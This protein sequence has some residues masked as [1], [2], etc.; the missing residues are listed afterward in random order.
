MD[1]S[2]RQ[3]ITLAVAAVLVGGAWM[4][5][6]LTRDDG[7]AAGTPTGHSTARAQPE[8]SEAGTG[9]GTKSGGFGGS[10]A[11]GDEGDEGNA[12]ARGARAAETM[13]IETDRFVATVTSRNTGLTSFRVKKQRYR[14]DK[15]QP[16][17]LVTTTEPRFFP[18]HVELE[19]VDIPD[20]A[21]WEME[22][23]SGQGIRFHWSGDGVAI[24]RKLQVGKGPYQLW[25]TVRIRNTGTESRRLTLTESTFHYIRREDE[26][27]GFLARPSPN[28]SLGVCMNRQEDAWELVRKDREELLEPHGYGPPVRY[29]G[30]QDV[31]FANVIVAAEQD[32]HRCKMVSSNRGGVPGDPEGSLFESRL[33]YDDVELGGGKST[34]FRTF[35]YFGPKRQATLQAAGRQLPRL[36]DLGWF[37]F[38]GELLSDLLSTIHEFVGNWGLAIILLTL[39]VKLVLYPLTEK[40]FRSMARMRQLKP[41]MDRINELYADDKEKK[42][43]AIMEL[44]RKHKINP[45][46]GCL[47]TL[48]Q[49]P[50]WL[51]LYQSLS[52]NVEL[53]NADFVLW[54]TD[55]SSPDPYFVL[56][57]MVGGLMFLQQRLTPTAMD[58]MQAK[59]M[60]YMMPVMI[61]GFMLFLPAGLCLYIVT[62]SAL[63]IGQQQLIQRRLDRQTPEGETEGGTEQ[64]TGG[65]GSP[66]SG[67]GEPAPAPPP[68][69]QP[70]EAVPALQSSGGGSSAAAAPKP[71][72]KSKKPTSKPSSRRRGGKRRQHRGR[73]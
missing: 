61:T 48:L 22:R 17:Q 31:Y 68:R 51:A 26:G 64:S 42:G 21:V 5:T 72:T 12:P 55:L 13:T 52:T 4:A 57:L 29:T 43:A 24:V 27:G 1:D 63:S 45:L 39:V 44:Y 8:T 49:L 11:A 14:N 71:R 62:N 40:S 3:M 65:N 66:P 30:I 46:G 15:G 36:V 28:R 10:A 7:G 32:A 6:D 33:V 35:A 34:T 37:A 50:I 53:Y 18:L 58:P 41:E 19:G 38:I 16:Q 2:R 60:M 56:P 67:G 25:S 73:A 59:I 20:D 54:W 69:N 23:L 70:T 47:P 9:E